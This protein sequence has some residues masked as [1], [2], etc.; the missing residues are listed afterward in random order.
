MSELGEQQPIVQQQPMNF[1]TQINTLLFR[2]G[3]YIDEL[4]TLSTVEGFKPED[5]IFNQ[6]GNI[7]DE[8]KGIIMAMDQEKATTPYGRFVLKLKTCLTEI[9]KLMNL[10]ENIQADKL[11]VQLKLMNDTLEDLSIEALEGQAETTEAVAKRCEGTDIKKCEDDLK[12]S[13]NEL[14]A[15]REKVE[16]ALNNKSQEIEEFNKQAESLNKLKEVIAE[17]ITIL[18]G[19]KNEEITDVLI[20]KIKKKIIETGTSME[21]DGITDDISTLN[22]KFDELKQ[23]IQKMKEQKEQLTKQEEDK[24]E[25]KAK[26]AVLEAQKFEEETAINDEG[27]EEQKIGSDEQG[28]GSGET[29]VGEDKQQATLGTV[30]KIPAGPRELPPEIPPLSDDEEPDVEETDLQEGERNRSLSLEAEDAKMR[31]GLEDVNLQVT[32]D[33]SQKLID[34]ANRSAEELDDVVSRRKP[35]PDVVDETVET[36]NI[37]NVQQNERE[38]LKEEEGVPEA[39][40]SN[41]ESIERNKKLQGDRL[42][43]SRQ[44]SLQEKVESTSETGKKPLVITSEDEQQGLDASTTTAENVIKKDDGIGGEVANMGGGRKR[45]QSKKK[46]RRGKRK[47]KKKRN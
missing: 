2:A 37:P 1:D 6:D 22:E 41:D 31:E 36:E 40:S 15:F 44:S 43:N 3:I 35:V 27:T 45:K 4:K 26:A 47:S 42:E 34:E 16:D 10:K 20:D 7:A 28:E 5:N 12:K 24:K 8:G 19:K 23:K 46:K 30:A 13:I 29:V 38:T 9:G 25:L 39:P 14:N 33:E 17:Q 18:D 21:V 32:P 11:A